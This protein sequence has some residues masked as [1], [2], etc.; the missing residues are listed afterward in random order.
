MSSDDITK[1]QAKTISQALFPGANYLVRL[2]K[3]MEKVGL[4]HD[5]KLYTLVC[6]AY[7]ASLNVC[8]EVHSMSC[9]G[10]NARPDRAE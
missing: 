1:S 6:L 9:D 4:P 5:D 8:H 10:S 2:K 3:K 7:D